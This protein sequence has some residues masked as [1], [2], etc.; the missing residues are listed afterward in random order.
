[1]ARKENAVKKNNASSEIN[2]NAKAQTWKI[3]GTDITGASKEE[4][5]PKRRELNAAAGVI[6]AEVSSNAW[7]YRVTKGP[8]HPHK[9]PTFGDIH[10]GS[11]FSFSGTTYRKT[12]RD[13]AETFSDKVRTPFAEHTPVIG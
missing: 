7:P 5:K 8:A 4:L 9:N 1:M 13:L 6:E 10:I 3:R 12:E 11:C 2:S